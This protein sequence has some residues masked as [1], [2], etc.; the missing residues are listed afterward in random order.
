MFGLEER[1]VTE[2]RQYVSR[3]QHELKVR[4]QVLNHKLCNFSHPTREGQEIREELLGGSAQ[5]QAP[6]QTRSTSSR[7]S[8]TAS[9]DDHQA[10]WAQEEQ[11]MIMQQ[12]DSTIDVIS[13]TLT[14]LAQ[15]AG[16]IGQ[17]INE[18]NE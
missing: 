17:E 8:P 6:S 18:H 7:H 9:D 10:R 13:G 2:R 11:Q 15:Q 1:E 14:T 16:L 5:A 12:Q 4:S 3:V